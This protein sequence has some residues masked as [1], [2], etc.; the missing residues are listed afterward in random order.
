MV[1]LK[2]FL[3]EP[4]AFSH[5]T[6]NFASCFRAL[7]RTALTVAK[8]AALSEWVVEYAGC[9]IGSIRKGFSNAVERSG[10]G[11]VTIHELRHTSAVTMLGAGLPIEKVS[12]MLGHSNLAVTFSTYAR[13]MPQHMQDAADVLNLLTA[14]K[15]Y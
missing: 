8:E 14:R 5:F 4:A 1:A 2:A 11:H 12:Q 10:I 6:C 7:A 15:T 3:F 9:Q 13:Y